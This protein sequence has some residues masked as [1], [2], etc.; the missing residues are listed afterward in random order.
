MRGKLKLFGK[1]NIQQIN[2]FVP[3]IVRFVFNVVSAQCVALL[4]LGKDRAMVE[5]FKFCLE[6]FRCPD[7]SFLEKF[8]YLCILSDQNFYWVSFDMF[9]YL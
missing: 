1:T 7:S 6:K 4:L 8:E 3:S 5:I 9:K 2:C